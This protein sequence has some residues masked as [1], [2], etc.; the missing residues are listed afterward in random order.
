MLFAEPAHP[1]DDPDQPPQWAWRY[2][3]FELLYTPG[4]KTLSRG[5]KYSIRGPKYSCRRCHGS[6]YLPRHITPDRAADVATPSPTCPAYRVLFE[7]LPLWPLHFLDQLRRRFGAR[8]RTADHPPLTSDKAGP[9]WAG[10]YS[11]EP[12]F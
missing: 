4:I 5:P 1:Y 6:G 9:G 8:R 10:G 12:P 11:D 3:Y 7:D 2:G